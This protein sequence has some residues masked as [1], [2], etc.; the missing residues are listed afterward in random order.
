MADQLKAALAILRRKQVE[1]RTGLSRSAIYALKAKGEF[2]Q[3]LKLT[4]K[5]VGWKSSDIEAWL[6]SRVQAGEKVV[7]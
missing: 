4:A 2:P 7:A 1:A 6:E 5:A 3:P